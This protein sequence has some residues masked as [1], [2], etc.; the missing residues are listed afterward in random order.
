MPSDEVKLVGDWYGMLPRKYMPRRTLPVI[1][2]LPLESN[3]SGVLTRPLL[4]LLGGT[5]LELEPAGFLIPRFSYTPRAGEHRT[6]NNAT[7]S[8]NSQVFIIPNIA[9][10]TEFRWH[11]S[12]QIT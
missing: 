11:Y 3:G 7:T 9:I 8:L 1:T 2:R 6:K 12:T 4:R 10:L 5:V